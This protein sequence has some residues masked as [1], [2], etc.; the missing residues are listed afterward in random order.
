M[1]KLLILLCFFVS[2]L[3]L[4][5]P[6]D[7][8]VADVGDVI[9][10][11]FDDAPTNADDF[12]SGY[13]VGNN[14][15]VADYFETSNTNDNP[16]DPNPINSL[17][18]A[19]ALANEDC[20]GYLNFTYGFSYIRMLN[21]S[22]VNTA[23]TQSSQ[24]HMYFC[25]DDDNVLIDISFNLNDVKWDRGSGDEEVY[26]SIAS[27][28]RYYFIF[29]HT[30][31]N[32]FNL[33]VLNSSFGSV[34]TKSNWAGVYS[35][36]WSSFS[37]IHFDAEGVGG[38]TLG[39]Y[40]DSFRINCNPAGEYYCDVSD[41]SQLCSNPL[42]S[43]LMVGSGNQYI[44]HEYEYD[45]TGTIY[46]VLLPVSIDQVNQVS[47]SVNDYDLVVNGIFC[48]NP[49][50]LID[51][52][53]DYAFQWCDI[54]GGL[55]VTLD[56]EKPLLAFRCV[57][58]VQYAYRW[59]WYGVG[60]S[61][62]IYFGTSR[63][64]NSGALFFNDQVDGKVFGSNHGLACCFYYNGSD[65]QGD[66]IPDWILEKYKDLFGNEF[67][68][69]YNYDLDCEYG[70][71]DNPWIIFNLSADNFTGGDYANPYIYKIYLNNNSVPLFEAPIS[72]TTDSKDALFKE[73]G[74]VFPSAGWYRIVLYNTSDYGLTIEDVIR[75]S[76]YVKVCPVGEGSGGDVAG[77]DDDDMGIYRWIAGVGVVVGFMFSPVWLFRNFGAVQD[78][79]KYVMLVFGFV[80]LCISVYYSLFP[81]WFVYVV[82]MI[83]AGYIALA[84]YS[85]I[86]RG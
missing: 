26:G 79:V 68:Q 2:F 50:F 1:K 78:N 41:F 66:G 16:N 63:Y 17:K 43:Y 56:G 51:Y 64:H 57:E 22:F 75:V 45:F 70:V 34:A 20:E 24:F 59:Y 67:I 9:I 80:G 72:F 52:G 33:E 8:V 7:V 83:T 54:N 19:A 13:F 74:F 86:T 85:K 53:D 82:G 71:G 60:V 44:E 69:F 30:T 46:S 29:T 37:Y 77:G 32:N 14:T 27:S 65:F 31:T 73:T 38:A 55:G 47:S 12:E 28:S 25:D 11:N 36:V 58:Y 61:D 3:V 23:T 42:D 6:V 21:F 18:C 10:C 40:F 76:Q 35:G 39:L 62:N 5:F 84:V 15:G 81:V 49:D 48:G 4:L